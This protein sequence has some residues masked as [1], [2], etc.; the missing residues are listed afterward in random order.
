MPIVTNTDTEAAAKRTNSIAFSVA[1]RL[2]RCARRALV[3]PSAG[4]V[5][6]VAPLGATADIVIV[7]PE[8]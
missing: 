3:R 5:A 1:M 6:E 2:R 7:S 8:V 4:T